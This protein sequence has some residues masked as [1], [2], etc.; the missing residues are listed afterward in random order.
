MQIRKSCST[1]IEGI[2]KLYSYARAQ[3]R[4]NGNPNQWEDS[5]PSKAILEKDIFAG[6]SY[7]IEENGRI[8]GTFAFIIGDDPTYEIIEKGYWLNDEPYGTIHRIASD[9]TIT[10]I[11][12]KCLN[13]CQTQIANIRVDTHQDNLIM[14]HLLD[15][16]GFQKCGI[17][18]VRDGTPRIAY[19][20]LCDK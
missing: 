11:F 19:Q 7:V 6:N 15:K 16:Y 13:Y 3:M 10:G 20:K 14:L 9:G 1:D 18:Y 4:Q 2:M 8:C 5:Y 17:I 12:E